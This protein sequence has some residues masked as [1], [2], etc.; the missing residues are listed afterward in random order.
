LYLTKYDVR[1]S[2][3]PPTEEDHERIKKNELRVFRSDGTTFEEAAPS[4]KEIVWEEV[5]ALK[6]QKKIR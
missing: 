2:H 3:Y 5:D 1:W 6:Y 4:N